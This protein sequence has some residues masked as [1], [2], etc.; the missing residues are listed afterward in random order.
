MLDLVA[1]TASGKGPLK[2][3]L[4]AYLCVVGVNGASFVPEIVGT[5]G[6]E[7]VVLGVCMIFM[8]IWF[9]WDLFEWVFWE[10]ETS[11]NR[12]RSSNSGPGY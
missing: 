2:E 1:L 6:L 9:V 3:G 8:I 11:R 10:E 4:I 7:L 5:A 12:A